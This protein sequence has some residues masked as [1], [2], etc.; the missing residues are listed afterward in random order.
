MQPSAIYETKTRKDTIL[1]EPDPA[2]ASSTTS[3]ETNQPQEKDS[4]HLPASPAEMLC[5]RSK[6]IN[7][8]APIQ[9]VQP[10]VGMAPEEQC[11][12]KEDPD[13]TLDKLLGLSSCEDHITTSASNSG[14]TVCKSD[15]SIFAFGTGGQAIGKKN[16]RG[17]RS[18]TVVGNPH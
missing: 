4:N 6:H 13:L 17:K 1:S 11:R 18:I 10:V 8:P 9:P 14:W 16:K 7:R 5:D 2:E 3:Q 12:K 15:H